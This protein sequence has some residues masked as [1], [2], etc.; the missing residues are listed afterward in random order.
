[1]LYSLL[2]RMLKYLPNIRDMRLGDSLG[3]D[4]FYE[5]FGIKKVVRDSK[6]VFEIAVNGS[7]NRYLE[8][9]MK[10]LEAL[11]KISPVRFWKLAR[12]LIRT[13]KALRMVALRNVRPLWYKTVDAERVNGWMKELNGICY[14]PR[15]TYEISRTG[16]PKDDGTLRY[17]ND[18]GVPWRMY[19]WM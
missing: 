9:Q 19:L 15:S 12:H 2:R 18:P 8:R 4:A 1:M 17:I 14:R 13:S 7:T 5:R 16:I 3:M 6:P 10:R 11:A